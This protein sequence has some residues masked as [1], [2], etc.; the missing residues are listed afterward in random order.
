M[1]DI[2]N[3]HPQY[4]LGIIALVLSAVVAALAAMKRKR[5]FGVVPVKLPDK[6]DVK[7]GASAEPEL[8]RYRSFLA[9]LHSLQRLGGY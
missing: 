8:C 1:D 4:L 7:K 5:I 2:I 9:C 3:N 6:S